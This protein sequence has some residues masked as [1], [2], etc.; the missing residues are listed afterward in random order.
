MSELEIFRNAITKSNMYENLFETFR[1]NIT[2]ILKYYHLVKNKKML[3]MCLNI[4]NIENVEQNIIV[5]KRLFE[6]ITELNLIVI[7]YDM[8]K[9]PNFNCS[10]VYENGKLNND[11]LYYQVFNKYFGKE[12]D[13]LNNFCLDI[14][15]Y[16]CFKH[17]IKKSKYS[18]KNKFVIYFVEEN[19]VI[20]EFNEIKRCIQY[21]NNLRFELGNVA[22]EECKIHL[23]DVNIMKAFYIFGLNLKTFSNIFIKFVNNINNVNKKTVLNIFDYFIS[24]GL[25][26]DREITDKLLN[27]YFSDKIYNYKHRAETYYNYDPNNKLFDDILPIMTKY[28][29]DDKYIIHYIMHKYNKND[30]NYCSSRDAMIVNLTT[31]LI[32]NL[33]IDIY[34][35]DNNNMYAHDYL[36][37]YAKNLFLNKYAKSIFSN[38]NLEDC[39]LEKY[40]NDNP[41]KIIMVVLLLLFIHYFFL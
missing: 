27:P 3:D 40:K 2:Y 10:Q 39:Y 11:N 17:I 26:F 34:L 19:D 41:G 14:A 13:T 37:I 36:N 28:L 33:N 18:T 30:L 8:V 31:K 4:S 23:C 29:K 22:L 24:I 15:N 38:E 35:K 1:N 32:H 16:T 5:M 7:R 6:I 12:L 25:K 20:Q 21:I 9:L